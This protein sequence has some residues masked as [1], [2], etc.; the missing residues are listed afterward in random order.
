MKK[1]IFL[2]FSLLITP[3]TF[4]Q[5]FDDTFDGAR[6]E[7]ITSFNSST[8]E[9]IPAA[10]VPAQKPEIKKYTDYTDEGM[11]KTIE[12]IQTQLKRV[13]PQQAREDLLADILFENNER[14]V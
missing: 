6:E 4:I 10:D 12:D 13:E 14:L 9:K 5:S 7:D 11:K 3:Y 2:I 1:N 8:T